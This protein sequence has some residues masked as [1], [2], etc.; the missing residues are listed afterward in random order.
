MLILMI[1]VIVAAIFCVSV[2]IGVFFLWRTARHKLYERRVCLPATKMLDD[3][4]ARLRDWPAGEFSPVAMDQI[5]KIKLKSFRLLL[6]TTGLD[7]SYSFVHDPA[8]G[9]WHLTT[10]VGSSYVEFPGWFW[11][12]APWLTSRMEK[13]LRLIIVIQASRDK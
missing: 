6:L 10:R 5:Y 11:S 12:R 1:T 8:D 7:T 9:T 13:I 3:L 2:G 4:S